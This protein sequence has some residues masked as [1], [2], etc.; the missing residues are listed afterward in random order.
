MGATH[1]FR[2][3]ERDGKSAAFRHSLTKNVQATDFEHERFLRVRVQL[4]AH[5]FQTPDSF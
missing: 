5:F 3:N 4:V 1:E 2:S